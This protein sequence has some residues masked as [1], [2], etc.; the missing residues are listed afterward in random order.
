MM[1]AVDIR[2]LMPLVYLHVCSG[3]FER[4]SGISVHVFLSLSVKLAHAD[5]VDVTELTGR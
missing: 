4:F 2:S 1:L 3:S 5:A